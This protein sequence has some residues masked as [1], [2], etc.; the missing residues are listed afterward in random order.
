MA[1]AL[2]IIDDRASSEVAADFLEEHGFATAA[3]VLRETVRLDL[4][5]F[6]DPFSAGRYFIGTPWV[7]SGWI[8][9]TNGRVAVRVRTKQPD[10]LDAPDGLRRPA[11][12]EVFEQVD[13]DFNEPSDRGLTTIASQKGEVRQS[14]GLEMIQLGEKWVSA[15]YLSLIER[16]PGVLLVESS[17]IDD[18]SYRPDQPAPPV[19]FVFVGGQA[20]LMPLSREGGH[21]A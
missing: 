4:M 7:R 12:F 21:H 15:D 20:M 2:T 19:C 6:C 13:W 14:G 3:A 18:Q 5:P 16:L 17:T 8:Y 9:A 1:D 10:N 11:A